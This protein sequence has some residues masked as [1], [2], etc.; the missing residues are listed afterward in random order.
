MKKYEFTKDMEE[1]SGFGGGYEK[2]CRKMLTAGLKWFDE[3]PKAKPK[4][5]GYKQI[6]GIIGE[7]NEDA[8]ALSKAV[9]KG[10]DG[11]ATGAMHQAV[12]I[13]IL[14]IRKNGWNAFVK[15]MSEGR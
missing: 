10:S 12:I 8:R 3:N 2:T 4:F 13:K 11:E 5:H 9:I 1:I 15:E 6:Y 14:W 7:D